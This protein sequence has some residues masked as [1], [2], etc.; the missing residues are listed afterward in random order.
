MC[1]IV[2][3]ILLCILTCTVQS[4]A[5]TSVID[6]ASQP[7]DFTIIG[8]PIKNPTTI[9]M[10]L[11]DITGDHQDEIFWT[12]PDT[13]GYVYGFLGSA[14]YRPRIDLR[15]R[16]AADFNFTIFDSAGPFE[17]QILCQDFNRD[18]ITDLL[19]AF[20]YAS[21]YGRLN[22]GCAFLSL[23]PFDQPDIPVTIQLLLGQVSLTLIGANDGDHLGM[24]LAVGDVN[25]D[26]WQDFI[27]GADGVD[28]QEHVTCGAAFIVLNSD[29][30]LNDK[31]VDCKDAPAVIKI[32]GRDDNDLSGRALNCGDF[33]GDGFAD[34]VIGAHKADS[35][36]PEVIVD[37]GEAYLLRGR[38][39]WSRTIDL[40]ER[41]PDLTLAG[42][43]KQGWLGFSVAV[44]DV[45]NDGKADLFV[46]APRMNWQDKID[47]GIVYGFSGKNLQSWT[48]LKT[49][50]ADWI[51]AGPEAYANLGSALAFGQ[52]NE[53]PLLDLILAAPQASAMNRKAAGM[54]LVLHDIGRRQRIFDLSAQTADIGILGALASGFLGAHLATGDVNGDGHTDLVVSAPY[55]PSESQL[56]GLWGSKL[57][58][59]QPIPGEIRNP[60]QFA[61]LPVSP[62]P[63]HSAGSLAATSKNVQAHYRVF[64]ACHL[65]L[66]VYDLMGR[67]V[68]DLMTAQHHGAGIYKYSWSGL[69]RDGNRVAAGIY[70]IALKSRDQV[71]CQRIVVL[72]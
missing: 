44:A 7:A 39:S 19:L 36:V 69:D 16:P 70:F 23:G 50:D 2:K 45:D 53:E 25:G 51:L 46:S 64:A 15:Q 32:Y 6:L 30:L 29:T 38:P 1:S 67:I 8:N 60:D 17:S 68:A 62:N 11:G 26:G 5:Q 48:D 13:A 56:Y 10:A 18:N 61:M 72:R 40:A 71:R 43:E 31:V 57:A 28:N 21:P 65:D 37:A 42:T 35:P 34:L 59:V 49:D 12:I 66:L 54:V 3:F 9:G 33:D 4:H 24:A 58:R 41:A 22:A 14:A 20:P 63:F 27:L 52:F 55:G 47:A